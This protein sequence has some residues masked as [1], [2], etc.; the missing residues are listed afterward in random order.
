MPSPRGLVSG[1]TT[2][3]PSSAAARRYSPL[4][5]TL[6]WVQVRPERYQSTGQG[7]SAA[8]GGTNTAK[9]ISHP[10]VAASWEHTNCVPPCDLAVE[11]VFIGLLLVICASRRCARDRH[12]L[13]T[14]KAACIAPAFATHLRP[15]LS[16]TGTGKAHAVHRRQGSGRHRCEQRHR[17]GNCPGAGARRRG[18]RACRPQRRQARPARRRDRRRGGQGDRG[19]DRRHQRSRR[20]PPFRRGREAG[21]RSD[22][23]R[24]QCR[25]CRRYRHRG[26]RT[27]PLASRAEHQPDLGLSV[28]ARGGAGDEARRR[29]RAHHQYRLAVGQEPAPAFAGLHGVEVRDGG[30]DPADRARRPR[31]QHHRLRAA[32]RIDALLAGAG[33]HRPRAGTTA[34][35]RRISAAW[36]S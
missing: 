1:H 9:V 4:S 10:V 3:R 22:D 17:I 32:S 34:S 5:I 11:I 33:R 6:A 31:R 26:P 25:H 29:R 15:R 19:A 36:W 30:H 20:A 35:S 27:G 16:G 18:D 8:C 7:P 23:P 2:I 28:F 24:Q 14:A 13:A 21:R 12:A